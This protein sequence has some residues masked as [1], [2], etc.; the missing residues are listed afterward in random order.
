MQNLEENSDPVSEFQYLAMPDHKRQ[1]ISVELLNLTVT[2]YND[3][4][5]TR[6]K[7]A[8]EFRS[9]VRIWISDHARP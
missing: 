9:G 8:G 6:C 5:T 7:F 1:N 4:Y 2:K 3:L